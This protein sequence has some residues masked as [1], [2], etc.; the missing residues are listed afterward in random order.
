MYKCNYFVQNHRNFTLCS[1]F[2]NYITYPWSQLGENCNRGFTVCTLL[3]LLLKDC[4]GQDIL[5]FDWI[6]TINIYTKE[7]IS[8]DVIG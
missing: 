5:N 7:M 4:S 6:Y 8:L 3:T 1:L 2:Y